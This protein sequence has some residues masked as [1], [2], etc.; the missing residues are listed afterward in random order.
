MTGKWKHFCV[1]FLIGDGMM[2]AMRPQRAAKAWVAG[3]KVWR[4]L[5][6]HLVQHPQ[7]TRSIGLAETAFGV[8]WAIQQEN[9]LEQFD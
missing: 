2:A 5:M 6:E 8:W 1:M 7:L 9:E 4:D 3:P